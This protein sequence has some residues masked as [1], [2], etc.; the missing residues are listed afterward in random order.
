MVKEV[1]LERDG[2][3]LEK[4]PAGILKVKLKDVGA[5][6]RC[7]LSGKMKQK[8]ISVIPG[9]WVKVEVNQY[10]MTQGRIVYR[11]NSYDSTQNDVE[12]TELGDMET[13]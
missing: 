8:H 10:D 9:D 12:T 2:E 13:E 11:Y 5:E 3:V 4:L 6:I 7:K 1:A